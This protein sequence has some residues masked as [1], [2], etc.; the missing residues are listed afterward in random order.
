MA[1]LRVWTEQSRHGLLFYFIS[2]VHTHNEFGQ[3]TEWAQALLCGANPDLFIVGK[4]QKCDLTFHFTHTTHE[5][6]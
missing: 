6:D 5:L 4:A 1:K 2:A 3:V